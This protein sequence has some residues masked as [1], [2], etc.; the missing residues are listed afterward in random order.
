MT[1]PPPPPG[2]GAMAAVGGIMYG[3]GI[4]TGTYDGMPARPPVT[5][6]S[7]ARLAAPCGV[8]GIPPL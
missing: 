2:V 1:E 6:D 7:A 4:G 5:A 8:L 3:I